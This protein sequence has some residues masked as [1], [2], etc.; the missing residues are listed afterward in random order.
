MSRLSAVR[1]SESK[2]SQY[3]KGPRVRPA[4]TVSF[5]VRDGRWYLDK[6]GHVVRPG[7]D[8]LPG[9]CCDY[10]AVQH[11]AALDKALSIPG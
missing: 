11:G 6:P 4:S 7:I 5:A 9:T 1:R 2:Q 3:R 10:Y 8:Q